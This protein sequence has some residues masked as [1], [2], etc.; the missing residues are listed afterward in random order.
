MNET[1]L[2][3]LLLSCRPLNELVLERD[4]VRRLDDEEEEL[5]DSLVSNGDFFRYS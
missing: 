5:V 1:V 4:A 2:P 3:A